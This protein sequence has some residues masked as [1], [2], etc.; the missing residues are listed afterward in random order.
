MSSSS[1]KS[2]RLPEVRLRPALYLPQCLLGGV[3]LGLACAC[4]WYSSLPWQ[5]CMVLS[6]IAIVYSIREIW[7]LNRCWKG[8][9]VNCLVC[10]NGKWQIWLEGDCRLQLQLE[11]GPLVHPALV[12]ARFRTC[13][14]GDP[15]YSILLFA[16]NT[17]AELWRRLSLALRY[18]CGGTNTVSDA[19]GR[20]SG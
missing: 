17:E 8:A 2:W 7:R 4:L 15:P 6:A 10:D 14:E 11:P 12:A 5:A 20:N 19:S 16:G 18:G 1:I 3:L 13:L 9:T